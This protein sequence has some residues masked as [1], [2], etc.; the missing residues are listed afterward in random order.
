MLNLVILSDPEKIDFEIFT[1]CF[2][3]LWKII[4]NK[5]M[6]IE[7]IHRIGRKNMI[8]RKI[9]FE[10]IEKQTLKNIQNLFL[11]INS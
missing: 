11:A 1:C 10:I 3:T 6:N 5:T 8:S 7:A 9:D 4:R 2:D